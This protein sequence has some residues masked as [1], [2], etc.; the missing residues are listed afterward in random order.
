LVSYLI[1]KG[2]KAF[3]DHTG[4]MWALCIV[5]VFLVFWFFNYPNVRFGWAWVLF[6]IVFTLIKTHDVF[7]KVPQNVI[8]ILA[9]VL[10]SLTL[11][12]GIWKSGTE[13]S[14]LR[15]NLV[16]PVEVRMPE[17]FFTAKTGPFEVMFTPD[18]HCWGAKPPCS[19]FYYETLNIVP[20]G[21]VFTEGFKVE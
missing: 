20:R 16:A 9:I 15:A 17:S 11:V 14:G 1:V 7:F 2:K 18:M 6:I 10:F 8:R 4:H 21:E 3:S 5:L 12:R 13:S 19:P